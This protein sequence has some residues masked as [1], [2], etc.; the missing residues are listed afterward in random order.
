M[1]LGC[2]LH[3][4]FP[5]SQKDPGRLPKIYLFPDGQCSEMS[6]RLS[7]EFLRV[8]ACKALIEI[9]RRGAEPGLAIHLICTRIKEVKRSWI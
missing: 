4:V 6:G 7:T 3:S 2:S 1:V 8:S 5:L 9:S